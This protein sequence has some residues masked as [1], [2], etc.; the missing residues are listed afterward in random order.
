MPQASRALS[1]RAAVT[2]PGDPEWRDDDSPNRQL[3]RFA[4]MGLLNV[5]AE[6]DVSVRSASVRR[7]HESL[8]HTFDSPR[9]HHHEPRGAGHLTSAA[10]W[11]E[12]TDATLDWLR[13][14]GW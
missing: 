2:L 3:A 5:T 8:R 12:A 14:H 10:P 6:R 11:D 4:D 13:R 1:K 7:F 9:H